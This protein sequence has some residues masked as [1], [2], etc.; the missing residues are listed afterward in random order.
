MRS[1][2]NQQVLVND[3]GAG[4]DDGLLLGVA[5]QTFAEVDAAVAAEI[6]DW[7][8]GAGVEGVDIALDGGE[9][10]RRFAV[11]PVDHGAIRAVA[12]DAGVESPEKFSGGAVE[13]DR[14]VAGR[15]AVEDAVDENGLGLRIA[16]AVG[17]VVGPGDCELFHVGAVDLL[18]VGVADTGGSAAIG[19]PI[20]VGGGKDREIAARTSRVRMET[21]IL[22]NHE[23]S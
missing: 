5:A 22:S 8:A 3:A 15:E 17:G 12:G 9:D 21:D 13:R 1:A 4:Q 23:D 2:D 19:G 14:F 11:G 7:F 18:E 16:R 10:T 20:A 6:G